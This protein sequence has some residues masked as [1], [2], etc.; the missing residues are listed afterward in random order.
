MPLPQIFAITVL[1]ERDFVV[2]PFGGDVWIAEN[3]YAANLNTRCNIGFV[4]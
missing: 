2:G 1:P 4:L 3:T